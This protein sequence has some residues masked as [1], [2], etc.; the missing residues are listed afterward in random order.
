[1]KVIQS[2]WIKLREDLNREDYDQINELQYRCTT[3]DSVALKLELDYKLS[4]A[5]QS[6]RQPN[7]KEINE[8]MYFDDKQLIGYIGICGFGGIGHPIEITGMVDPDYRRQGVFTSLHE[9]VL[10]ECR[11]RKTDSI[12]LLCDKA[13]EAGQGF[14]KTTGAVYKNS[15]YEMYL[16]E[17]YQDPEESLFCGV[18]L[19]KAK[20]S[21]AYEVMRQN[22][23]YFGDP[24]PVKEDDKDGQEEDYL[25]QESNSEEAILPEEEEK[26]GMTIYLAKQGDVTIG[27]VHLENNSEV[28]GI[29]GLGVLP[30]FRGNGLGRALLL[31]AVEQLR[32]EHKG[33]IMLQVATKNATALNLYL[34]CGF[35]ETSTMDYYELKP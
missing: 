1:M 12:L 6:S 21:D 7:M 18:S 28:R 29:Y 19:Q 9:L 22:A 11:R 15:E 3:F 2:P 27:K 10:A 20:N 8:F 16:N 31:R 14:L 17:N 30:E 4:A 24:I 25:K 13:S 23:I 26:R 35:Y 33:K 5:E 34:S 32:Q